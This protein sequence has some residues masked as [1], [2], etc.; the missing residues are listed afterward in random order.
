M[1]AVGGDGTQVWASAEGAYEGV[2]GAAALGV[3]GQGGQVCEVRGSAAAEGR[4]L[5]GVASLHVVSATAATAAGAPAASLHVACRG[6]EGRGHV[7]CLFICR[8]RAGGCGGGAADRGRGG[9]GVEL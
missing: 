7:L 6:R 8:C 5:H 9:G 2:G 1:G 3:G 4:V